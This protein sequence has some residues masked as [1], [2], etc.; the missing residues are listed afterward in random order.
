M[1]KAMTTIAILAALT[2]GA[3]QVMAQG[4]GGGAGGGGAG[5]A[6]GVGRRS[7]AGAGAGGGAGDGSAAADGGG[8][9]H[10]DLVARAPV[11]PAVRT[12]RPRRGRTDRGPP[13]FRDD[14]VI[15]R[16]RLQRQQS[17]R[18]KYLGLS[19]PV[20]EA[21]SLVGCDDI[22]YG[23]FELLGGRALPH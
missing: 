14:E 7:R 22:R 16:T 12:I 23:A 4:G 15:E 13:R 18:A 8:Q 9:E 6:G 3:S 11:A 21:S 20:A 10:Y 5:G 2:L 1:R 19:H 17:Y